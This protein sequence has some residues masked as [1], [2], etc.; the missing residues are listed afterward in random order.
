MP[1]VDSLSYAVPLSRWTLVPLGRQLVANG[2]NNALEGLL[3]QPFSHMHRVL[4]QVCSVIGLQR[5]AW[6]GACCRFPYVLVHLSMLLVAYPDSH[7]M[8]IAGFCTL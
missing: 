2:A 3:P 4:A 1:N 8:P 6:F 7:D 5:V